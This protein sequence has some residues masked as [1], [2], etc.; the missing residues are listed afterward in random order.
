MV[1]LGS[2]AAC[3]SNAVVE[4]AG[5]ES[6]DDC[7]PGNQCLDCGIYARCVPPGYACEDQGDGGTDPGS[8]GQNETGGAGATSVGGAGGGVGGTGGAGGAMPVCEQIGDGSCP[9][10]C[11]DTNDID[12]RPSCLGILT[13]R[14]GA[15][16]GI[17]A[18]DPDGSG[19]VPETTV[20]CDMVQDQG[21]WTLVARFANEDAANWM[22]DSGAWWYVRTQET[23]LTTSR[24]DNADMLSR[25]FWT[26]AGG[27]LRLSRTDNAD[28][29][30]LLLTTSSCL[31][32]NNFRG[33]ITGLGDFQNG[34]VWGDD[35]V[36]ST[37]AATLGGNYDTTQGFLSATCVGDIGEPA[38]VSF[39][40]DWS[41]DGS[42]MMIGGGGDACGRADHGIGITEADAGSFVSATATEGNGEDDF[43]NSG[44]GIAND[45]PYALNLWVR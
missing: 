31:G 5:C 43:G 2:W 35:S 10:T 23:G 8:G 15:T 22:L 11:D 21:G 26:V 16:S 34:T 18:I 24:S 32:G 37:C 25:A 29:A 27:E 14:P 7:A 42:V 6:E 38:S 9:A 45:V 4:G 19:A 1:L 44:S 36:L 3:D 28:D 17:Y 13:A 12:C 41:N 30:A 33:F 39:W 40:A 20:L